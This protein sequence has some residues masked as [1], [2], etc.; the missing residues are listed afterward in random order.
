M[1]LRPGEMWRE[2]KVKH[3]PGNMVSYSW[4]PQPRL[5]PTWRRHSSTPP[6]RSTTRSRR[7][8]LISTMR[9][10]VSRLDLNTV[11]QEELSQ[12]QED[13]EAPQEDVVNINTWVQWS[14]WLWVSGNC[15]SMFKRLSKFYPQ[16]T[17]QFNLA[18]H[19]WRLVFKQIINSMEI[20]GCFNFYISIN[21]SILCIVSEF[22]LWLF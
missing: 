8:C 19:I 7:E 5:L 15:I 22:L 4:R 17:L 6:G 10:M 9:L 11:Q 20:Y 3:L 2:R 21:E 14:K 16:K 1:I 12:E 18:H 13:R